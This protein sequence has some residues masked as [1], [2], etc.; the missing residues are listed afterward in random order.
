[1]RFLAF[2]Q[3]SLGHLWKNLTQDATETLVMHCIEIQGKNTYTDASKGGGSD[4][5]RKEVIED[6]LSD[7][8]LFV[9]LLRS[10]K[11]RFIVLAERLQCAVQTAVAKHLAVITNTLDMVRNENVALESE[12]DPEFRSRV[13]REMRAIRLEVRR[14]KSATCP[15]T[16]G[17]GRRVSFEV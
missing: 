9:S 6:R 5:R 10:F 4:R 12:R 15:E 14:I 13:E 11:S 3:P 16:T 7:E 2:E 8:T 1:M 17:D